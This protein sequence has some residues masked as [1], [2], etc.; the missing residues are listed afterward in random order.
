MECRAGNRRIS[1]ASRRRSSLP[2]PLFGF[3][4]DE[5]AK[6]GGRAGKDGAAHVGKSRLDLGI[7]EDAMTV[8][9]VAT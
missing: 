8:L 1:P 4:G 2:C 6:V 7:G 5:L 3:V 9:I